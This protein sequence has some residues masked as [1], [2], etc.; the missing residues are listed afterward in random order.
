MQPRFRAALL[1]LLATMFV[2]PIHARAIEVAFEIG[3]GAVLSDQVSLEVRV[4][5]PDVAV[6]KVEFSVDG[7]L[8]ATDVSVPYTF[9]WD[10]LSEKE[11]PYTLVATAH[12]AQGRTATAKLMVKIDNE[13]GKGADALAAESIAALKKGR[14]QDARNYARR[15]LKLSPENA[16][17]ARALAAL[18]RKSGDLDRAF[19]ILSKA[20]ISEDDIEARKDLIALHV[21]KGDSIGTTPALAE[22]A[23]LAAELHLKILHGRVAALKPS[24]SPVV[25]GDAMFAA[26]D[27]AGATREYQRVADPETGKM[28]AVNRLLLAYIASNR[29]SDADLLLRTLTRLNR[30]DPV[31][32]AVIGY[33]QLLGN[34]FEKALASAENAAE[35]DSL[36]A[37]IVSGY[38]QLALGKR[39]EAAEWA[40]KAHEANPELAEVQLLRARAVQDS[41]D[42]RRAILRALELE[43]SSP[44]PYVL[45]GFQLMLAKDSKRFA[46]SGAILEAALK[47]DPK[48]AYAQIGLA[49]SLMAQKRSIEADTLLD[50][51]MKQEPNAPDAMAVKALNLRMMDKSGTE[52]TRLLAAAKKIDEAR[53]SDVFVPDVADLISRVYRYRF[54]VRITPATLY[55]ATGT[56]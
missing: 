51:L 31:T 17:A 38:A 48:S 29:M 5:S 10:T 6:D 9:A 24:D 42:S 46:A 23:G 45:H 54:P 37:M 19:D 14:V 41:I 7:M 36:A 16:T 34:Q 26:R 56:E 13:F 21:A 40:D 27:W 53:W 20:K 22:H 55:P 52:I 25:R 3:D 44:E 18:Y 50:S 15:A 8:R 35:N 49:L 32:R 33:R 47:R 28:E 43:P 2:F 30:I 1:P 39:R 4:K 11:G 12:D